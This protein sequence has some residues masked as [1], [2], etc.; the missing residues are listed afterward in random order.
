MVSQ[1]D[2]WLTFLITNQLKKTLLR[3]LADETQIIY[4]AV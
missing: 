2:F 1:D 4:L 3:R